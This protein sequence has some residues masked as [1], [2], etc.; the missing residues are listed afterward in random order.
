ME[1][2]PYHVMAGDSDGDHESCLSRHSL[3][4]K[5]GVYSSCTKPH[6]RRPE[7]NANEPVN[8]SV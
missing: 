3:I 6:F 1:K 8:N 7:V 2:R 4:M 5:K